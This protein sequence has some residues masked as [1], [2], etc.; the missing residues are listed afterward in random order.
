MN[1]FSA[2]FRV[3]RVISVRKKKDKNIRIIGKSEF[4]EHKQIH[5]LLFP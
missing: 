1:W 4:N 5:K 3:L 2:V